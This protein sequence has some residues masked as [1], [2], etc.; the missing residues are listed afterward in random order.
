MRLSFRVQHRQK[1]KRRLLY[2]LSGL[3]LLIAIGALIAW[4][5]VR[6]TI[7]M[8]DRP[9]ESGT[10][11]APVIEET[12][13][14]TGSTL[15]ILNE[16]GKERFV[17]VQASPARKEILVVPVP[18]SLKTESGSTLAA[19]FRQ[20]GSGKAVQTVSTALQ[21]PV[22]HYITFSVADVVTFMNYL[23]GSLTF[24]L[25]ESIKYTDENGLPAQVKAGERQ[26]NANQIAGVL[27]HET[28]KKP[29]TAESMF[30]ELIAAILNQNL[31]PELRF[32]G[33][34]AV[35]CN[36]AQTDLRIDHFNAYAYTLHYLADSN[37]GSLCRTLA[38]TGQT[39]ADGHFAPDVNKM[40]RTTPLYAN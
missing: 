22:S 7:S 4:L 2:S 1:V 15:L 30:A 20:Q 40:R 3:A 16:H 28:W 33:D 26:L 19:A 17:L 5:I 35:L 14:D 34:F 38:L 29:A 8:A 36:T 13:A 10:S 23:E 27:R 32:G 18:A 31:L 25:P 37:T 11:S 39:D 9:S 12:L 21:L 6:Y 24:Q